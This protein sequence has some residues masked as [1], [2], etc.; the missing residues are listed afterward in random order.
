MEDLRKKKKKKIYISIY[1][2][3]LPSLSGVSQCKTVSVISVSVIYGQ[4]SKG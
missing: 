3:V 2:D 1:V 4:L